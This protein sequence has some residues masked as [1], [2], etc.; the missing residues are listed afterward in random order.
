MTFL[1]ATIQKG[2][3]VNISSPLHTNLKKKT[4][5]KIGAFLHRLPSTAEVGC[6]CASRYLGGTRQ[7]LRSKNIV[8][9]TPR[10]S[11]QPGWQSASNRPHTRFLSEYGT[12][13]HRGWMTTV[14]THTLWRLP[15]RSL[16]LSLSLTNRLP[17][18]SQGREVHISPELSSFPPRRRPLR[19]LGLHPFHVGGCTRYVHPGH[20]GAGGG[21]AARARARVRAGGGK[22][23]TMHGRSGSVSM[24]P[25]ISK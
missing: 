5:T 10:E 3:Q 2:Q 18:I 4:R 12:P 21:G 13:S 1:F 20:G 7:H 22:F 15:L 24:P 8:A 19:G 16:F 14:P 11:L 6:N 17:A 25:R 23:F 9:P